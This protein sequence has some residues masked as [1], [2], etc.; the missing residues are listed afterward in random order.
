[1]EGLVTIVIIP[2]AV[3]LILLI[4]NF[5]I[6]IAILAPTLYMQIFVNNI[7]I[8]KTFVTMIIGLTKPSILAVPFF[9][10]AGNLI[11]ASGIG[12]RIINFIMPKLRA[13]RGGIPLSSILANA[14]FGAI[15]GSS[16]AAVATIGKLTFQPL[17]KYSGEK[18]ALGVTTSSGC[19]ATII[20]PSISLI[21]YGIATETSIGQL[22][23]AGFIPGL[24]M[25]AV[26]GTYVVLATKSRP[27]FDE[28]P[29][30]EGF[31]KFLPVL[32]MPVIVLGGIY[33]GIF[34]PVEAGAVSAV[35][36]LL[37]TIFYR[38]LTWDKLKSC[39]RESTDTVGRL[40]ILVAC[41]LAFAESLT[42]SGITGI[43]NE[44]IGGLHVFIFLIL[45]NIILLIAGFFFEPGAIVLILAPIIA[46][47]AVSMGIHPLHLGI[48][49]AVNVS[50]GMFTPPFGLNIFVVQGV[51]EQPFEKIA[52]A[53]VPFILTYLVSL[54]IITFV[55][56]IS[57]WLPSVLM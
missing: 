5:P 22:F 4:L 17:V 50:I 52:Q 54:V 6:Y 8:Q 9:I 27:V 40:F 20:P 11:S 1:V 24:V 31:L 39:L 18:M 10:V 57:L 51:L 46:P 43:I 48:V 56:I 7:T 41:S 26:V 25:V 14:F 47:V 19:I 34:T 53:V 44:L 55:P 45:L 35:Y 28:L 3:M 29:A 12:E 16:P 15:S 36:A 42:L 38:E 32:L 2:I 37:A 23:M 13:I 30:R 33:G 49:F 21:L